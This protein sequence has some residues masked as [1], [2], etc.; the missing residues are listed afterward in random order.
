MYIS[1][2]IYSLYIC[3]Y[4]DDVD[5]LWVTNVTQSEAWVCF[6]FLLGQLGQG[7]LD[8]ILSP[9]ESHLIQVFSGPDAW[10][11]L[12]L[13]GGPHW[14]D[15]SCFPMQRTAKIH[16]TKMED[17][18]TSSCHFVHTGSSATSIRVSFTGV[19]VITRVWRLFAVRHEVPCKDV[20]VS[21]PDVTDTGC[22]KGEKVRQ[23]CMALTAF[24]CSD[25]QFS[26]WTFLT[27]A[28][29][30]RLDDPCVKDDVGHEVWLRKKVHFEVICSLILPNWIS[31]TW[32]CQ[33]DWD[34]GSQSSATTNIIANQ[35]SAK[36]RSH[37][38]VFETFLSTEPPVRCDT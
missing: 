4:M 5:L 17:P 38:G 28:P 18:P 32:H 37:Q 30:E 31:W 15:L 13:V 2:Y 7:F 36:M 27:T 22:A 10:C 1:I 34:R 16:Q 26:F 12:G 25:F 9:L 19:A 35:A 14:L 8:L 33:Q 24:S 3:I 20:Q 23:S 6:S 11:K 21:R 29:C